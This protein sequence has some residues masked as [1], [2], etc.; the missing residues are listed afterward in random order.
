M[1]CL[2]PGEGGEALEYVEEHTLTIDG[3]GSLT[4]GSE[5]GDALIA[6]DGTFLMKN[7]Y[8]T[9]SENREAVMIL[10][11]ARLEQSG[12]KIYMNCGINVYESVN[13][14]LL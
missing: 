6:T 10:N 3:T 12:G 11:I 1:R 14:E 2:Y 8:L 5:D 9:A 7:G 4:V 13:Q